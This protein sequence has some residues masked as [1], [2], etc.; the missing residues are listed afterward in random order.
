[1][2]MLRSSWK[3][4]G[5][6][7]M[8]KGDEEKLRKLLLVEWSVIALRKRLVYRILEEKKVQ[9]EREDEVT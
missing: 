3:D 4:C 8:A 6:V 1:M 5:D 2:K 7:A 9:A